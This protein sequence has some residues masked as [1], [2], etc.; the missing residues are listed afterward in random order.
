M[1]LFKVKFRGVYKKGDGIQRMRTTYAHL[2]SRG[3]VLKSILQDYSKVKLIYI[4]A[5]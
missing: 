5:L 1:I 3:E 2:S 4:R